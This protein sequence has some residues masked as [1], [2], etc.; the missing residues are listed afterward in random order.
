[1]VATWATDINEDPGCDRIMNPDM[2]LSSNL[3]PNVTMVLEGTTGLSHQHRLGGSMALMPIWPCWRPRTLGLTWSLMVSGATGI[4][5]DSDCSRAMY[6]DMALSCN[7]MLPWHLVAAQATQI[8]MAS[9][10]SP[11]PP[12]FAWPL[13]I[14]GTTNISTDPGYSRA[15]DPDMTLSSFLD[16]SMALVAVQTPGILVVFGGNVG[17]RC[18]LR[19]WPQ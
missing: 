15:T 13:V 3:G 4:S 16:V 19:P 1:M 9:D 11:D 18:Q 17:H 6:P 5:T 7:L 12:V 8:C 10:G 14:I 2:I